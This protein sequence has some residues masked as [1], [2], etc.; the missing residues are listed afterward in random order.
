MAHQHSNQEYADVALRT[1][2]AQDIGAK[3]KRVSDL[4]HLA[5]HGLDGVGEEVLM[6]IVGS[7]AGLLG[8][9]LVD[10]QAMEGNGT[11]IVDVR[12]IKLT[13]AGRE[14]VRSNLPS[15]RMR[16]CL[17]WV[18]DNIVGASVSAAVGA[19]VGWFLRSLFKP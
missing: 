3:V 6:N 9:G 12:N 4:V 19:L 17:K 7:R 8:R 18:T 16:R 13:D 14:Y 10:C 11:G 1:L 15:T 2:Y 5:G